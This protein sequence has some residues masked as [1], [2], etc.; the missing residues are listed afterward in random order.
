MD[1]V[2]KYN[3]FNTNTPSSESYRNY[4]IRFITTYACPAWELAADSHLLKLQHL[5]NKFLCT[6]GNLPRRTSTR[7]LHMAF[8]IPYLHDFVTRLCK[9]QAAVILNHENINIR[10]IGQDE[11]RH[12]KYKRLHL[13]GGQAYDR[14]NV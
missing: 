5:E 7:D 8:K 3:S 4:L 13:G 1:K 2:Q 14:S 6:I 10:N 12:R 9:Q 11:A